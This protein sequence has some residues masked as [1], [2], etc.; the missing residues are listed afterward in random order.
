VIDLRSDFCA[1]PT[2]EMWA[3]MRTGGEEDVAEL[4][5]AAAAVLGKE[6][7]VLV[8][9]GTA[10]NLA[11]LLALTHPGERVAIDARAHIVVNE[12]D[13]LTSLAGLV[14]VAL[15]EAAP[16]M[17]LENTHTRAGGAVLGV[18][19]TRA[20][21][22]RAE[23]V[24][25]DGAR[26][27]NAAVALGVPMADLAGPADTVALSLSKG[28]CAPVGAVLAG[29]AEVIARA[30]VQLER[31]GGG[32]I[33][34][35]GVLAAAGLLALGLVDRLAE[36]H[37][38]ARRL[39]EL[40]GLPV[41]Q[42]NIVLTGLPASSLPELAERGVRALAPDGDRVRLVTHRG[43]SDDDVERAAAAVGVLGRQSC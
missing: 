1:P 18:S 23:R 29:R 40:L 3:A 7:A 31:L 26:L 11:A 35:A 22:A 28:L 5:R 37:R 32:T 24:H 9:T 13:W 14:P 21:A 41:P 33:H 39:A 16:V 34:K 15:S 2:D 4:E 36:D 42:T 10:A 38:R 43:I 20:L 12:G 19:D 25:L 27:P 17:C 6:A 8:A 30:R